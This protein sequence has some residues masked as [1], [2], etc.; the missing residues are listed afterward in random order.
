[1][2]KILDTPPW[3]IFSNGQKMGPYSV[4]ELVEMIVKGEV[5]MQ[6]L[7]WHRGMEQW[8]KAQ[9]MPEL[10]DFFAADAGKVPDL[11]KE[12]ATEASSEAGVGE[13]IIDYR[14]YTAQTTSGSRLLRWVALFLFLAII[15]PFLGFA[16][17]KGV[18][19]VF[20]RQVQEQ[21]PVKAAA[22]SVAPQAQAPSAESSPS[23]VATATAV[24]AAE[25][26][27]PAAPQS[28]PASTGADAAPAPDAAA[29]TPFPYPSPDNSGESPYGA[30]DEATS[31]A[32]GSEI[33]ALDTPGASPAATEPSTSATEPGRGGWGFWH[34]FP[35][36]VSR[37]SRG[38]ALW[39]IGGA[40]YG[41]G[42]SRC[43]GAES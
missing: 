38:V 41:R 4:E 35:L 14:P 25:P 7:V 29:S 31:E 36:S 19:Y 3:Y 23:P 24:V 9:D 8:Q 10:E 34:A 22:V 6:S 17:Y 39:H 11:E 26:V 33:P 12:P 21:T 5:T 42:H 37:K 15:A 20:L 1:M 13:E 18:Q 40:A 32:S 16:T 30:A 43:L 27:A 2:D 28:S